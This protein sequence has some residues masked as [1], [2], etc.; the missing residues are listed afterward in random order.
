MNSKIIGGY[1]L[2]VLS[3]G[4]FS[5]QRA[6][7]VEEE[8]DNNVIIAYMEVQ[9]KTKTVLSEPSD[10]YYYALWAEGD[11][12]AVFTSP[13]QRPGMFHLQDG[14]GES[15]AI[16]GGQ[17]PKIEGTSLPRVALFPYCEDAQWDKD[18]LTFSLP[19]EQLYKPHSFSANGFPMIAVGDETPEMHFKNLCSVIHL[20]L[21]GAER[22]I[23]DQIKIQSQKQ[24]LCGNVKVDTRFEDVPQ[25]EMLEGGFHE[26]VLKCQG[27]LLDESTPTDF[28]VVVPSQTYDDLTILVE[29]YTGSV[30]KTVSQKIS[31]KR[32]EL[33]PVSPFMVDVPPIDFDNLPENHVWY[34]T[35]DG[36]LHPFDYLDVGTTPFNANIISH[37]YNGNYGVM[38]LSEPLINV[39]YGAFNTF[40]DTKITELHLPDCV[41]SLETASIPSTLKTLRVPSSIKE[42]GLG[43]FRYLS[44]VSGP[45][46]AK[47]GRSV[48]KDNVLLGVASDGI[49]I[50][51]TPEGVKKI[52]PRCFSNTHLQSI[53]ISEGVSVIGESAFTLMEELEYLS[54]PASI[55]S[56]M[57][58]TDY[59]PKLK[60]FFGS[61]H[62][63]SADNLCLIDP[64][65]DFGTRLV[66]IAPNSDLEY[67]EIPEGIVD[68]CAFFQGWKSL[69]A[70][71]IPI[72]LQRVSVGS[73]FYD[74]PN[75]ERFY[76]Y[77]TSEDGR[78]IILDGVVYS[79]LLHGEK[80]Y[81]LPPAMSTC[82]SCLSGNTDLVSVTF[83]RGYVSLGAFTFGHC[84]NLHT[85]S[86]PNSISDLGQDPFYGCDML[87][88]VYLPV[89]V[90]PSIRLIYSS[91]PEKLKIYVPDVALE[92]YMKDPNWVLYKEH[93]VAHH[94]DNI[95]PPS[96]YKSTDYT[97]DGLVTVL[98]RASEGQGIDLVLLG[99]AFSDRQ[100]AS[101]EYLAT[102]ETAAESFFGVEPYQSFRHLFN[103]YAVNAVSSSE[104]YTSG[105]TVFGCY[106]IDDIINADVDKCIEYAL[107]AIS[108]DRLFEAT[109]VLVCNSPGLPIEYCKGA[110]H[111]LGKESTS[112]NDYGSG[113]GIA[114]VTRSGMWNNIRHEACGH[115]F[116]KLA[117][118]YSNRGTGTDSVTP[119]Y[120]EAFHSAELIGWSKNLDLTSN[121][122]DVKWS[123]FLLDDRY[124]AEELGVFEGGGAK[125]NFGVY[126]PSELSI[127]NVNSLG[128]FNAPS[129]EAIYYRIHKL[130]YGPEWQYDYEEFVRW[131]QGSKNIR[132]SAPRQ[133]PSATNVYEVRN[134]LPITHYDPD[135]WTI[136]VMR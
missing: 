12:I 105:G 94:F 19:R 61:S 1:L 35:T 56:I 36:E 50:Y 31:M 109:I 93:L 5:C 33:R 68:I 134:P 92:S 39:H 80:E 66:A 40:T 44:S 9:N 135:E 30:T 130:A 99:D 77:A 119:D 42:F 122:S 59:F 49:K 98:Q 14:A 28:F 112:I 8:I 136:T 95:D 23:L 132:P 11:T 15:T 114:L 46:V 82:I 6:I 118:E 16:F 101:G 111:M 24:Y 124:K 83:S 32:S 53:T 131:D 128:S 7:I 18:V 60:G 84:L 76:G 104:D 102:M 78:C 10:G 90:P 55:R 85:V 91:V 97:K 69:R 120:I 21:K 63:T 38:V 106:N 100:I 17:Y 22:V 13:G 79:V 20:S 96:P 87:E 29:A 121:I 75:I 117:D 67:Y 57:P 89:R 115:G 52:G 34:K 58:Q 45:L 64:R 73:M 65:G 72:S 26:V 129:R 48:I 113:L 37:T 47:D 4:F 116:A 123:H 107:K 41:E 27:A 25:L 43:L 3:I 133:I 108:K 54:L 103:V 81:V 70:V 62:C 2:A 125:Y 88:S 74:C 127:M 126:R 71:K 110:C 86:L 51:E